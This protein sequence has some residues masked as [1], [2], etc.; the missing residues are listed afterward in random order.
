MHPIKNLKYFNWLK[1]KNEVLTFGCEVNERAII[2]SCKLH[3]FSLI[4]LDNL[5]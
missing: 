1:V 2:D 4:L 3:L 5:I